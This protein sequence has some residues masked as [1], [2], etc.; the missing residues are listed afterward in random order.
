MFVLSYINSSLPGNIRLYTGLIVFLVLNILNVNGQNGSKTKTKIDCIVIDAGHG[1]KDPGTKNGKIFEKDIALAIALKLGNYIKDNMPDVKVIYTRDKDV[2]VPLDERAEIAN[3]N[4][5]D[6]FISIHCNANPS[7]VPYGT[8]TYAMGLTKAAGNLEVAKQENAAIFFEENSESKYQGFDNS[9]ESYIMLSL[10]Q[11]TH[12]DQSI[13][14]ASSIQN[15]FKERASRVDRGVKQAGF[16]VLWKT[17]MPSVLIETGFLSNVNECKYLTSDKGQDYLASAIYRAFKDYKNMIENKS[18]FTYNKNVETPED[19]TNPQIVVDTFPEIDEEKPKEEKKP[20]L[21]PADSTKTRGYFMVQICSS[22]K[23]LSL[24][25]KLFKGVK[26]ITE[27]RIDG[28]YKYTVGQKRNYKDVLEYLNTMKKT[29][30]DAF[31]VGCIDGKIV[32]AKEVM[33]QIKAVN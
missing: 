4:Q 23:P 1:G 19:S 16:I 11:N 24:N 6:V 5:A 14:L 29:F 31:V 10:M 27:Y 3:K 9:P 8:E 26:N 15:Q 28:R 33:N 7:K 20:S 2:F 30:P 12:I 22:L 18:V 13:K 32:P 21:A 25:S 17:T